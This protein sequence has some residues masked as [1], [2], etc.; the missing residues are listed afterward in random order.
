MRRWARWT[1]E[2]D[3]A[4]RR[5]YPIVGGR[6]RGWARLMPDRMPSNDVIAHR[7]KALG[8]KC[9]SK[10][11]YG[12]GKAEAE[13]LAESMMRGEAGHGDGDAAHNHQGR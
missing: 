3:D 13:R 12:M 5:F 11:S 6:W 1:D 2:E 7:A 4:I 10:F 8:V 9:R